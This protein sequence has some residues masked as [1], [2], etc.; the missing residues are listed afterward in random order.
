[1]AV[2]DTTSASRGINHGEGRIINAIYRVIGAAIAWND[3]RVTRKVLEQLS[4]HELDDIGLTRGD[5]DRL[6]RF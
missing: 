5:L 2:F 3:A 6:S 1:M 4:E